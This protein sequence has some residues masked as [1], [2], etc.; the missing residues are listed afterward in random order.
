VTSINTS[1]LCLSKN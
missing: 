1:Q